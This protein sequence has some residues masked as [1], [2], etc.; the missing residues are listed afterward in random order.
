MAE[1]R[2]RQRKT[3]SESETEWRKRQRRKKINERKTEKKAR[4]NNGNGGTTDRQGNVLAGRPKPVPE[5]IQRKSICS[6]QLQAHE[7]EM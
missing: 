7:E 6:H 1:D 4:H 5:A 2:K 3:E